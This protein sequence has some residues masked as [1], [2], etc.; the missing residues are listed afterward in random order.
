MKRASP[1][2]PAPAKRTVSSAS[3]QGSSGATS[4]RGVGL[5]PG[6]RAL[7]GSL[8]TWTYGTP[9]PSAK[10]AAFDFDGTLARCAWHRA[11]R[12]PPAA[13]LL[14]VLGAR[15]GSTQL[16]GFDPNGW[17]MQFAQ[18][19]RVLEKLAA[20]GY[21]LLIITNESLDRYKNVRRATLPRH[22]SANVRADSAVSQEA[23]LAKAIRKK[24]GRIEGFA[25]A[26]GVP[27]TVLCATAKDS[28]RKP[29]A[30]S[31]SHF[32][33]AHNGGVEVDPTRS[34][35]VGDAAG[36]PA[37]AGRKEDFSDSD[38]AFAAAV[39]IRFYTETEFFLAERQPPP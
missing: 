7:A 21:T 35:Y 9:A 34:F 16:Q 27:L 4:L 37:R 14:T 25:K 1:F 26:A 38:R 30:R 24:V 22:P 3:P 31:W 2:D 36:R 17:E 6:W 33:G 39:G 28:Y 29:G 11:L 20:D 23:P 13:T 12:P 15:D 8:L 5:P 19:P 10:V 18:V 32:A